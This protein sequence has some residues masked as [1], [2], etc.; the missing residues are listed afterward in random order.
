[1][2]L[3]DMGYKDS[4]PAAVN[5]KQSEPKIHYPSLSLHKN[6]PEEL[7]GKDIG[8]VCRIELVVKVVGKSIDQ[9]SEDRNERVELEVHK[10]GFIGKAG[11][12]SKEEYLS[13]S[14]EERAAYDKEQLD[15]KD[16]E[17]SSKEGEE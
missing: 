1:M 12:L 2:E 6:I 16:E 17:E 8:E 13:K 5:E 14:E 15:T 9:Y 11:K 4:I 10:L 3:K 7:M